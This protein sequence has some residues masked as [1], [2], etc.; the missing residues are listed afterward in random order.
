[1]HAAHHA[2]HAVHAAVDLWI[3][4]WILVGLWILVDAA[5][6][7]VDTGGSVDT[8]GCCA[9][10]GGSLHNCTCGEPLRYC[11]YARD[12]ALLVNRT[13]LEAA[14]E[15]SNARALAVSVCAADPQE[16]TLSL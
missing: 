7:A 12:Q 5:H 2:V 6:A 13:E 10:C 9:C 1:M 14:I 15:A 11:R 8:G 3:L 16:D 4:R